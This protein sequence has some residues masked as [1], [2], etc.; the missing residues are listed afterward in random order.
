MEGQGNPTQPAPAWPEPQSATTPGPGRASGWRRT[1][2]SA[3]LAIGLLTV[4]GVAIVNAA[5]PDPSASTAPS[6][7]SNPSGATGTQGSGGSGGTQHN[8]PNM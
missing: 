7:S 8:C 2:A 1:V 6:A 5:S 4:G 3:L